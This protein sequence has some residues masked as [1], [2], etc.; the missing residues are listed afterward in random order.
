MKDKIKCIIEEWNKQVGAYTSAADKSHSQERRERLM[1]FAA[2]YRQC[3]ADLL[4]VV[5]RAS[6]A[7]PLPES[8][9]ARI[10]KREAH[11]IQVIGE[12]IT[13]PTLERLSVANAALNIIQNDLHAMLLHADSKRTE[14]PA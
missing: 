11:A 1:Q 8:L 4:D 9:A 10:V 13:E 5:S 12:F 3:A 14:V 7:E 2:I 6:Q